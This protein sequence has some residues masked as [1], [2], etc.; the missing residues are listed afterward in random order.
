[1][2]S[3]A[4][5]PE[6][7]LSFIPGPGDSWTFEIAQYCLSS[8]DAAKNKLAQFPKG[9]VFVWYPFNAGRAEDQRKLILKEL[10]GYL[11]EIGM[12]LEER[13]RN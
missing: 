12:V 6:K 4:D 11:T 9:T 5:P 13:W 8:L 2:I 7:R 10:K 1:M 3:E